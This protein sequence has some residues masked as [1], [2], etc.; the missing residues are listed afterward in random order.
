MT[1]ADR[2]WQ[3][4]RRNFEGR[5]CGSSHWYLRGEAGADGDGSLDLRQ[6]SRQIHD[7]CYA[8]S[9]RDADHGLWD[10]SGLLFAPGGRRQLEISRSTYNRS[11]ACW[12]FAGAGGQSSLVLD[13]EQSRWGHEVNFFAGRSRSMLVLLWGRRDGDRQR[14]AGSTAQA[15]P[16]ESGNGWRLDSIAA[17]AFRCTLASQP[18]P[19]RAAAASVEELLEEQRGWPGMLETLRPG[20]WPADPA[21]AQACGGFQPERFQTRGGLSAGFAD[22]LVCSV[23]EWLPRG[24]FQL[25]VGC[26]INPD[27]FEQLSLRIDAAGRLTQ[28]QR[29]CFQRHG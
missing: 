3:L 8:I 28:W 23:P 9:F 22:G 29:R 19:P 4:N 25:Q 17:V 15:P 11:G 26:R 13:P 5:W 14:R 10:G 27:R 7:T 21:P 1:G 2:Q 20:E 24:P 16:G 12:Q 6:P 18:D